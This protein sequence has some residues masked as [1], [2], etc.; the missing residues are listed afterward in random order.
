[1]AIDLNACIG[2]NACVVACVAENNVPVVGKE[3]VGRGREMHWLRVDRITPVRSD[4]PQVYFQPLPCMHCEQAPC[5][6][7]CPV[8][9]TVHSSDGLNQMVYNRCVGTRYARELSV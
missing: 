4:N 3:Q 1:M 6:V 2:C 7:V 5:E 9:S 8:A